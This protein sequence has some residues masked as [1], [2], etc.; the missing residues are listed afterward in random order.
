MKIE[1]IE[2][3]K[4]RRA[5]L[6]K[7]APLHLLPASSDRALLGLLISNALVIDT[8]HVDFDSGHLVFE[9]VD[10]FFR[11]FQLFLGGLEIFQ[12]QLESI[13]VGV[14]D[15]YVRSKPQAN[16]SSIIWHSCLGPNVI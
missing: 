14:L 6:I 8:S 15:H 4:N 10:V 9:E 13:V 1:L 3:F 11:L 2:L 16:L 5:R 12:K 7:F